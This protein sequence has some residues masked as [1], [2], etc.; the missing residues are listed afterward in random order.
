MKK[1]AVLMACAALTLLSAGCSGEKK[2]AELLDTA[3]FEEKQNNREHAAKLYEEIIRKYPG[4]PSAT[5]A[6][7]RLDAMRS[8]K[9]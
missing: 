3:R 8:T 4:S 9:P 5:A 2:A 6:V 7:Q 1:L